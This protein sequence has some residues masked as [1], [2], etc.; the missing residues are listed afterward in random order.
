MR[1]TTR[2][3]PNVSR[4]T[5]AEMMFELSP[6]DTAAKRR[7]FLDARPQQDVAVETHAEHAFA[8]ELRAEPVECRAVTVDDGDIVA[9]AGQAV[10]QRCAH[11]AASH[12]HYS[13]LC[14]PFGCSL[15]LT[16]SNLRTRNATA[17]LVWAYSWLSC[18]SFRP[19]PGGWSSAGRS[20]A[21]GFPTRCLPK[22]IALPVFAS[23]ALSSV[24]YAPE[25]IFL[26]LSVAGPVR[27]LDGAVDRAGR[28]GGDADRDRQLPAER[29]RIPVG[30]WRLRGGHH[31]PRPDRRADGGQRTVGG[32]R[33]D[34]R[35]VDG[36]GDVQHRVRGAV[37]QHAQGVVRRRSRS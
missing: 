29:A 10:G 21:T 12:H 8:G 34:R 9:D 1:A 27:V 35:G 13:H 26:V 22:R 33:A 15:K 5:R 19:P 11:P 23:D 2:S 30:R 6:E 25:E 17:K 18:P 37:H 28:R 3:T 4:A 7:R 31:Q 14:G 20:A 16:S 36:V 32:L 24:A